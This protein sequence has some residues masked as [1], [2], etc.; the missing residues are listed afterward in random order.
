MSETAC[1]GRVEETLGGEKEVEK[2][3]RGE[4]EEQPRD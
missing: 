2:E 1:K 3:W 4:E